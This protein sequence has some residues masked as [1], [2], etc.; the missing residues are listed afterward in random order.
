M[1]AES[2]CRLFIDRVDEEQLTGCSQTHSGICF[3]IHCVGGTVIHSLFRANPGVAQVSRTRLARVVLPNRYRIQFLVSLLLT[4]TLEPGQNSSLDLEQP[5][6][7]R[8]A[9]LLPAVLCRVLTLSCARIALSGA[10]IML[11][12]GSV[13]R[14]SG[15]LDA[16]RA[17]E[18]RNGIPPGLLAA[19]GRVES[20]SWSWSV[21]GND[22]EPGRRFASVEDAQRYAQGLLATGKRMIDLGCFQIDLLYHE[23]VFQQWQDAFDSGLNAQAAAGILRGLH[24]RT[25]DWRQAVALY[26][27]ADPIR[28]QSYLHSVMSAWEGVDSSSTSIALLPASDPYSIVLASFPIDIAVWGPGMA[29]PIPKSSPRRSARALPRVVTP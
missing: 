1:S 7:W 28:G 8:F 29:G 6:A 10:V 18:L 25:G 27:S 13:A 11:N 26:H 3:E 12:F 17:A 14:A 9:R 15:C 2:S 20:G 24:E 4:R 23:E 5:P 21:N 19:I 16:A 22:A